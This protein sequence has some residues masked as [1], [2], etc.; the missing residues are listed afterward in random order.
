MNRISRSGGVLNFSAN[1][2]PG[3]LP[4]YSGNPQRGED[5]GHSNINTPNAARSASPGSIESVLQ[6]LDQIRKETD[7]LINKYIASTQKARVNPGPPTHTVNGREKLSK[8]RD[9]NPTVIYNSEAWENR[10]IK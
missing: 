8:K 4:A 10:F 5:P 9:G 6:Q 2:N 3:W 1:N 7:D